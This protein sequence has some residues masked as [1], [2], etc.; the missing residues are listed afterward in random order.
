MDAYWALEI[1][2]HA[3][4]TS[5]L[6]GGR[7]PRYPFDRGLPG[8]LIWSGRGGEEK[9]ILSLDLSGIETRSSSP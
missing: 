4:L 3:F 7:S 2:L 6:G 5:A 1:Q 9:E 8:P